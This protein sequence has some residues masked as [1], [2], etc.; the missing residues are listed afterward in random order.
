MSDS[1]IH[2][3]TEVTGLL[4]VGHHHHEESRRFHQRKKRQ[5]PPAD[6][7]AP[8]VAEKAVEDLLH[9]PEENAREEPEAENLPASSEEPGG[10]NLLL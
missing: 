3:H 8:E 5:P 10:L 9:R 7:A 6:A 1:T 2:P 4:G